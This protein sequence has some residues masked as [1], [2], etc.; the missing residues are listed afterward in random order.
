MEK[1]E[2]QPVAERKRGEKN[3]LPSSRG[4][5]SLRFTISY[6]NH[7]DLI[8]SVKNTS[9]G[10]SESVTEFSSFVNTTRS[11]SLT[12]TKISR[13]EF[14]SS[15]GNSRVK[16]VHTR[17]SVRDDANSGGGKRNSH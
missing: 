8:G 4:R 12:K 13:S 3:L 10:H 15:T 9:V 5:T 17:D 14:S 6:N 16:R 2:L 7:R 1:S 11:F